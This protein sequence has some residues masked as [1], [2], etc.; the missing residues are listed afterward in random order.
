MKGWHWLKRG[1]SLLLIGLVLFY[2]LA[3]SP[4]L[5]PSCRH[6][7]SCSEYTIL[8]LRG[9]GLLRGGWL[10]A[11]RIARCHPWGTSGYDPV[12]PGRYDPPEENET[13]PPEE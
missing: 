3:I 12:P 8:A 2:Q 7:P 6:T 5:G 4:L 11:R 1:P 9:H 13:M 10:S